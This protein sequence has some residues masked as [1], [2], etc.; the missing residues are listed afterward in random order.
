MAKKTIKIAQKWQ[1][2]VILGKIPHKDRE[3]PL[4]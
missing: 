2:K 4:A 3:K 1:K